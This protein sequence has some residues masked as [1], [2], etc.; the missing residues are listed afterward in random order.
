MTVF[1]ETERLVLKKTEQCHFSAIFKLRSDPEVMKYSQDAKPQT[2]EEVQALLDKII[3][4]QEKYG[5]SMFSAFEKSSGDFIGQVGLFHVGFA[6][7]QPEI[8][9]AGR[10]HLKYWRQ[11]Y[12]SEAAIVLIKWGF[13]H[14]S[15]NKIV[16]FADPNNIASHHILNK[17]GMTNLGI[18][19]CYYGNLVKYELSKTNFNTLM[20]PLAK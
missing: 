18:Q 7:E 11:G 2:Q 19:N 6:D 20:P 9:F 8:E 13:D 14:L 17:C 15:L 12:G 3:A 4:H 16:A 10:S 1:L 5:Y